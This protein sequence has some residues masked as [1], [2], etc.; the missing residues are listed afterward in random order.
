M[1][2]YRS[3]MENKDSTDKDKDKVEGK[4]KA[5]NKA[6][7]EEGGLK[8]SLE[9]ERA[10]VTMGCAISRR[11]S[12]EEWRRWDLVHSNLNPA[13]YE[14]KFPGWAGLLVGFV[15]GL[16][17]TAMAV[18]VVWRWYALEVWKVVFARTTAGPAREVGGGG[19]RRGIGGGRG[20]RDVGVVNRP[21][22]YAALERPPPAYVE[23]V[24]LGGERV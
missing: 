7:L 5:G 1:K 11:T 12:R 13:D 2:T 24:R 22:P 15:G 20:R 6:Q 16:L 21:P 14:T 3:A 17:M 4:D 10:L 9:A 8:A 19:G 18:W 23:M